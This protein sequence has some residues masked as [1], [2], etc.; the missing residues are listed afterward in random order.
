MSVYVDS[1]R[2]PYRGMIMCHMFADNDDELVAFA[3]SL[4]IDR[5]HHQ[6]PRTGRSH[7]D[8]CAAKRKIAVRMGAI[9]ITNRDVAELLKRRAATV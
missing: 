9:E 4:G 5:K 2:R 7:F 3:E 8:I 1:A 6:A